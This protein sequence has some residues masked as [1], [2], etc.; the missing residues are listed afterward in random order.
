MEEILNDLLD[1]FDKVVFYEVMEEIE[2]SSNAQN[3]YEKLMQ[4]M[5]CSYT[6][7]VAMGIGITVEGGAA[8]V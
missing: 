2:K 5:A 8:N 3:R 7:G 4:M 6:K 1:Y